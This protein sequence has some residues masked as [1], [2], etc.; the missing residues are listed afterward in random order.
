MKKFF[1]VF[2]I[3]LLGGLC[4]AFL[5]ECLS[6]S[7][8]LPPASNEEVATHT[9]TYKAVVNGEITDIPEGMYLDTGDYPAEYVEGENI[10]ISDL[11]AVYSV[12]S[13]KDY[14]FKGWYTDE[15]CT[16][17]FEGSIPEEFTGNVTLYA[18]LGV[19]AW[20]KNY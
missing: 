4:L 2:F 6:P 19:A 7:Q 9:I 10:T 16:Q 15:A 18:K 13:Y 1:T 17:S 14:E 12:S 8:E 20:T 11:R 3:I 5:G